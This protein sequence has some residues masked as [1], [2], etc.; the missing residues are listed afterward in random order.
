MRIPNLNYAAELFLPFDTH[1]EIVLSLSHCNHA[2]IDTSNTIPRSGRI[3]IQIQITM[4]PFGQKVTFFWANKSEEQVHDFKI[5]TYT[6]KRGISCPRLLSS[7]L[8]VEQSYR[9]RFCQRCYL[10][11]VCGVNNVVVDLPER[12]FHPSFCPT[13]DDSTSSH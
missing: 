7:R 9:T 11:I 6:L 1:L 8:I 12:A 10:A 2:I 3:R 5:N 13:L 4:I